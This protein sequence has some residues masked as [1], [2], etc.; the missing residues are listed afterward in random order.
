MYG[1]D[2]QELTKSILLNINAAN[3]RN[4]IED[5]E[6]KINFIIDAAF[7]LSDQIQICLEEKIIDSTKAKEWNEKVIFI[8]NCAVSWRNDL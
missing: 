7:T 8:R 6:E 3:N 1:E 4:K 2:I 5:K